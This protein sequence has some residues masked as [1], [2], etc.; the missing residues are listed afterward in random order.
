[1]NLSVW[2]IDCLLEFEEQIRQNL[3]LAASEEAALKAEEDKRRRWMEAT[4]NREKAARE[5]RMKA[6]EL[7]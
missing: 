7:R 3:A 1:M 5:T 4:V 6:N 2:Q